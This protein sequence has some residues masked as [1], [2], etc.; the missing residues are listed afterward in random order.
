MTEALVTEVESEHDEIVGK[1][2]SVAPVPVMRRRRETRKASA[3]WP[4]IDKLRHP[5]AVT[6]REVEVAGG[7]P[8]GTSRIIA[9]DRTLAHHP[10]SD[11][12]RPAILKH[13]PVAGDRHIAKVKMDARGPGPQHRITHKG[14]MPEIHHGPEPCMLEN[15]LPYPLPQQIVV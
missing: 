14:V 9:G 2:P 4:L 8:V 3:K 6:D 15:P 11:R 5:V 10:T 12:Q 7:H 13:Q 1:A